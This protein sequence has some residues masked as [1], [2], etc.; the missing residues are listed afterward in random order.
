MWDTE[1]HA[2]AVSVPE[3]D[4]PSSP[5]SGS[6]GSDGR[7]ARHLAEPRPEGLLVLRIGEPLTHLRPDPAAQQEDAP[8]VAAA[9]L[10]QVLLLELQHAVAGLHLAG[11]VRVEVPAHPVKAL[12][13]GEPPRTARRAAVGG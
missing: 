6:P 5:S 10:L 1:Q 2:E 12:A 11:R 13:A 9:Q 7:L 3:D 4:S 8:H